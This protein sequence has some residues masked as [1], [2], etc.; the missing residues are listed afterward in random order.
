MPESSKALL[1]DAA[2]AIAALRE[3]ILAIPD[4]VV[5]TLPAMPGVDGD[6]LAEVQDNLRVAVR[7]N[8]QATGTKLKA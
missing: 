1:K 5:A 3:Y 2:T 8:H 7:D 4:G 6:W